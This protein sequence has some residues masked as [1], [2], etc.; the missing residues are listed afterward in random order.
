[1]H[2]NVL[3]DM[4]SQISMGIYDDIGSDIP[5]QFAPF[6][7]LAS[8]QPYTGKFLGAEK[9]VSK[10]GDTVHW[11]FE[12]VK[13]YRFQ[14]KENEVVFM[15]GDVCVLNKK[16]RNP[17]KKLDENGVPVQVASRFFIRMK[18]NQVEPGDIIQIR[19]MGSG[20]DTTYDIVV[21]ERSGGE[22]DA[23]AEA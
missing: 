5:S 20:F 3:R 6:L 13:P 11:S 23:N 8:G 2:L 10:Y 4:R 18:E 22:K 9:A 16:H 12:T 15:P 17:G 21:L 19:Q 7:N 14:K 1:M